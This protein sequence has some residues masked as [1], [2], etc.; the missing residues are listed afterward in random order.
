[1]VS[2]IVRNNEDSFQAAQSSAGVFLIYIAGADQPQQ[3]NVAPG[4]SKVVTFKNV[5]DFGKKAQGIVAMF[6]KY[7]WIMPGTDVQ[8]GKLIK[9]PDFIITGDGIDLL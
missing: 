6:G 5:A 8:A 7:R 1:M 9:A 4:Q 2:F 3:V